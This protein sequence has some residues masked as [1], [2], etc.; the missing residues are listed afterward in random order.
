MRYSFSTWS[1]G[2][3]NSLPGGFHQG[4]LLGEQCLWKSK[5][6]DLLP[7][8]S[9][10][11]DAARDRLVSADLEMQASLPMSQPRSDSSR[12]RPSE[13]GVMSLTGEA[14]SFPQRL[15]PQLHSR[16][17]KLLTRFLLLKVGKDEL[18]LVAWT[19]APAIPEAEAGQPVS[20]GA[21]DQRGQHRETPSL[22]KGV[23][24]GLPPRKT[25]EAPPAVKTQPGLQSCP[26]PDSSV[27]R[28]V[29][30]LRPRS[31]FLICKKNH[32]E[33]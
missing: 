21:Q 2:R 10:A 18:S 27:L 29:T 11:T 17:G 9:S 3:V 15:S 8:K 31:R 5:A 26:S 16:P 22:I 19:G 1:R 24:G 28:Q 20:T 4:Q 25:T 6:Y 23:G 33:S 13:R 14:S 32:R 12:G 7:A 30:K